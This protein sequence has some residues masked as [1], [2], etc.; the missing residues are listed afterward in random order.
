[1]TGE[2]GCIRKRGTVCEHRERASAAAGDRCLRSSP[3]HP[4][5]T[6]RIPRPADAT[7]MEPPRPGERLRA[8]RLLVSAVSILSAPAG[9]QAQE[10][11]PAGL[12]FG[13]LVVPLFVVAVLGVAAAWLSARRGGWLRRFT[14][15]DGPV[16]VI[17]ALP[18]GARERLLVVRIERDDQP[19]RDLLLSATPQQIVLIERLDPVAADSTLAPAGQGA[20]DED[21]HTGAWR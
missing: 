18:L 2:S 13:D 21:P 1:M 10:S 19:P 11:P 20:R 16:R 17:Q 4:G 7:V 5:A 9:A 14:G 8:R 3:R 12:P 15:G 6:V